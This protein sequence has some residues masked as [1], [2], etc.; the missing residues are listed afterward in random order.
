MARF[1]FK[2]PDVGEGVT[3]GEIVEWF[4]AVGD[5]VAEDEPMVEVMTDKA[6]VTIGA[7][8]DARVERI[9]FEVGAV[10]QVWQVILTLE[11]EPTSNVSATRRS[12]RPPATA[13]G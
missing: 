1:D 2:L 13:V 10:A 12:S 9:C 4:V 11:P 5:T 7:P 3:E 6:T 8:C